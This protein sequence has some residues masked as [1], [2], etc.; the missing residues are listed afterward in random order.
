MSK[1]EIRWKLSLWWT[2]EKSKIERVRTCEVEMRR[3]TS[4]KVRGIDYSGYERD[5]DKQNKHWE[6]VIRHVHLQVAEDMTLDKRMWSTI[7]R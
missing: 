5:K 7:L 4:E 3:R 6:E 2:N 1:I